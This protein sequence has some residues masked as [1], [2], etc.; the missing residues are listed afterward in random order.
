VSPKFYAQLNVPN[1]K[2]R[3]F[4]LNGLVIVPPSA[5]QTIIYVL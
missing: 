5:G 4:P 2:L 3:G 1:Y